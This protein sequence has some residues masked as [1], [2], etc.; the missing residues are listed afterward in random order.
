MCA[1]RGGI[2]VGEFLRNS[3]ANFGEIGLQASELDMA[4][5]DDDQQQWIDELLRSSAAAELEAAPAGATFATSAAIG[6]LRRRQRRRRTLAVFASAA[7]LAAVWAWPTAKDAAPGSARGL[8]H[9]A[10]A[11]SNQATTPRRSRGLQE[12]SAS[13][14]GRGIF[15]ANGDAIAVELPSPAPE[16]TVVQLHPTTIAQRR[17][18]NELVLKQLLATEPNGG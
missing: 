16:V 15:I 18:Q 4:K 7:T 12:G 8:N 3:P 6:A 13:P 10:A 14:V 9:A 5:H 11:H 2:K 17:A 1:E